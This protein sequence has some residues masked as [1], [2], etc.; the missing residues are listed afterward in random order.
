[1][2]VKEKSRQKSAKP[3]ITNVITTADLEQEVNV[4]KF[5]NFS[6]GRCDLEDSYNEGKVGYIKS[7]IMHG[8]VTVFSSGKMISTGSKSVLQSERELSHA[9]HL[10]SRNHFI[11]NVTL[12]PQV[13]NVVATL[14]LKA[15]IDLTS[16][17]TKM[18]DCIFEPDQFPGVIHKSEDGVSY[19]VFSSGKIVIAGA[20][21]EE[22]LMQ[23]SKYISGE[24]E[25]FLI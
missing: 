21:S 14:D 16:V 24:L 9:K 23:S 1:M 13:R 15:R 18:V 25:R 7:T 20:R 19:L 6:W 12:R 5:N 11:N 10:L 2:Y 8:R 4:R 22:H 17:A 3:K